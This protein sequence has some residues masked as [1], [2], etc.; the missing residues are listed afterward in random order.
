MTFT[1]K[2]P[3]VGTTIFSQMTGL[4]NHHQAINLSQGF[5]DF[6]VA[7]ELIRLV[8]AYMEKGFN[9]YAPSHGALPLRQRIAAKQKALYGADYN[10][11]TEITVTSG[12]TEA[13]FA[14]I[15]TVV[16]PGDEVILLDPA[17]DS[18][19]PAVELSRGRP[20]H[21][22]LSGSTYAVDWDRVKDRISPK[23]RLLILN[24]PH[25]PT[26]SVLSTRDL[27]ALSDIVARHDIYILSDEVYEHIIFDGLKHESIS[28]RPDLAQKSF[29]VSSLGKTYHATGW[30]VGYCLAPE[31]LTREFRK[32]HQYLTFSTHTPTQMAY[33]DFL[34]HEDHY[35]NLGAFYQKKRDLFAAALKGSRFRI[36]PCHGSY[37]QMLDYSDISDKP[38]MDFAKELTIT[39]KVAAIP[40]SVFYRH[41]DDSR[42]LRFCFAKRD[43]TLLQ[44]AE[45][46]C[47]V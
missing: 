46:L 6:D 1:S 35:L 33:A 42:V 25:N 27:D 32:I 37:F 26:G 2:L 23:T 21:V 29:V 34:E 24:T 28:G 19:A 5:P 38:D 16:T 47:A 20:V 13:L 3:R 15:T 30:K 9:Q 45:K 44:A 39:H 17:Y 11:E 31:D 12:A 7:P 18:Y 36:I 8:G 43:E 14:A 41:G 40:P 10:L 22:R 4:A